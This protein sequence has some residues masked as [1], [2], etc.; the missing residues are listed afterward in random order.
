MDAN[1]LHIVINHFPIVGVFIGTCLLLYGLFI[2]DQPIKRAANTIILF[3]AILLIPVYFSGAYSRSYKLLNDPMLTTEVLVHNELAIMA[4]WLGLVLG[5]FAYASLYLSLT[6]GAFEKSSSWITVAFAIIVL[7]FL[8][9]TGA[10]GI[11]IKH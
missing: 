7:I 5:A 6:K 4:T 3:T 2:D 11:A 8:A 1:D 9:I 10:A